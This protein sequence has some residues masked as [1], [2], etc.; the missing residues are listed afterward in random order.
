MSTGPAW[1]W[2]GSIVEA[3]TRPLAGA[4]LSLA[5]LHTAGSG[6]AR[7]LREAVRRRLAAGG[8]AYMVG[9]GVSGHNSGV[10][11]V[12]A[13]AKGGIRL[14]AND[15]EERFS[16]VKHDDRFPT[17]CVELL[18][19]RLDGLGPSDVQ[20]F[21]TSWDYAALVGLGLRVVAEHLPS[22]MA[23]FHPAAF[24][25]SH[26]SHLVTALHA[27][28]TLGR[29]LGMPAPALVAVRHHD[30]HAAFSWAVSPFRHGEGPVLVTVLDGFGD[31]GAVSLYVADGGPP[32]PV[33]KNRSVFDSLGLFYSFISST[34]GGW[35]QLSSEGRYMGAAAWGD[36]ERLTNPYYRLLRQT[37]RFLPGGRV[38]IDRRL[39]NWP[40]GGA[41]WPY[42]GE[43]EGMIGPPIPAEKLW[44]PDAVLRVEDVEHAPVTRQRVD[45]AAATQLVFE[46]ALFHI[47][48]HLIRTTGSDRLVLTG[49]TAL[50]CLANM[51][52]VDHFGR[53]WYRRNLGRDACLHVWVPPVPG[54]AGAAAG[55]AYHLALSAGARPGHGL[56][57]AFY[58]GTAPTD[59][60]IADALAAEQAVRHVRLGSVRTAAGLRAVAELAALIVSEDGV[61][62]LFQGPAETGPRALGHRSILAN[63][64]NPM[65]LENINRRVKFREPIRPL[66]P[67]LTLA[68][69]RQLFELPEGA[70][71]DNYNA[72][73]YMVLTARARP[74]AYAL[75]PAVI[76]RD[77]T[78]RVQIVRQEHDPLTHAYLKALGRR[79]GVEASVNT[80][81]NVGSPIVQT[82]AQALGALKR[83][84]ALSG[85][86]LVGAEGGAYLA[87]HD[88][89]GPDAGRQVASWLAR[90]R[91]GAATAG[92]AS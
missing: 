37:F 43:L 24:P 73:N 64:R 15:E 84:K 42:T 12:E 46:D 53:D 35:T 80:S 39:A 57:H 7:R 28:R 30:T 68:A 10:A 79:I 27:P 75:V 71:D 81:L 26:I 91:E 33:Y 40:R 69:A 16:G 6:A 58:C 52:L 45:L 66:A 3:I 18:R 72:F 8:P 17:H 62:G 61:V 49:G 47:V 82:P 20:G 11:L 9:L 70:S 31:E 32:R 44:H 22:S 63:P 67:M 92:A 48:D 56:E 86:L 25:H 54:D 83:A 1:P 50:N 59:A 36:G 85:L 87:W 13:T 51:R 88:G 89:A 19:R 90:W 78:G 55:A 21:V 5:G 60:E 41:I 65:T 14:L 77:G 76:H 34:Q 29:Q 2:L 23:L 4:A 38:E 74:A